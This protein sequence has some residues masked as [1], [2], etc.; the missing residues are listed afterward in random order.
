VQ[1]HHGKKLDDMAKALEPLARIEAFIT[2]VAHD[3]ER[4]IQALEKR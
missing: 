3:H 1:A 2:A 4:R